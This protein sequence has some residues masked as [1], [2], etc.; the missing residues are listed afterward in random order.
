MFVRSATRFFENLERYRQGA[1]LEP[2]VNLDLG[3]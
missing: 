1:P 3:Y 2:M